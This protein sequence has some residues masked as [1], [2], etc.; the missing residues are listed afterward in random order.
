MMFSYQT[1]ALFAVVAGFV[2]LCLGMWYLWTMQQQLR[3]EIQLLRNTEK[4]LAVPAPV[5]KGNTDTFGMCSVPTPTTQVSTPNTRSGA[6]VQSSLHSESRVEHRG[7]AARTRG[8]AAEDDTSETSLSESES[9][10]DDDDE[11]LT[12][13]EPVVE[14]KPTNSHIVL[15][16]ESEP[17]NLVESLLSSIVTS[18][19]DNNAHDSM[20]SQ[21]MTSE[22]AHTN[23]QEHGQASTLHNAEETHHIL[24]NNDTS[25]QD[26]VTHTPDIT[27]AEEEVESASESDV[28]DPDHVQQSNA[29]DQ[30]TVQAVDVDPSLQRENLV[31]TLRSNTVLNLREQCGDHNVVVRLK[32]GAF[33]KKED[34]VQDLADAIVEAGIHDSTASNSSTHTVD[35]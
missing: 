30:E 4:V 27:T 9:D 14:T 6:L 12:D 28:D 20:V 26:P 1:I 25:E 18:S 19:V 33:K 2:I 31:K 13:E 35:A 10:Y 11:E 32:G 34:L 15:D 5:H 24:H 17:V 21:N 3:N 22:L 8:E 7:E 29:L 23:E 16:T